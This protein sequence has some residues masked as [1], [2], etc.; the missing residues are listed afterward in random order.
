MRDFKTGDTVV[1]VKQKYSPSPGPRARE[2]RRCSAGD[3]YTY[4]VDKYWRVVDYGLN[5]ALKVVTR[6]GK[7]HT[8]SPHDPSLRRP[9]I[10]E[11]IVYRTRFPPIQL[12]R[13]NIAERSGMIMG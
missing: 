3:D 13:D 12:C 9:N 8:L 2:L 11:R 5:G 10:W 6:R 7:V 1:Y 4:L